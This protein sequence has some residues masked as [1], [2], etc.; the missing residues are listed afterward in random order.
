MLDVYKRQV[1]S[2]KDECPGY[3]GRFAD[4]FG[5]H[6]V[7]KADAAGGDGGGNGYQVEHVHVVHLR[8]AAVHPEG[9]NQAQ[10]ALSLIHICGDYSHRSQLADSV[11]CNHF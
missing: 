9:D 6:P 4:D 11:G 5:V 2:F 8:L 3:V 1:F 10:R 7:G